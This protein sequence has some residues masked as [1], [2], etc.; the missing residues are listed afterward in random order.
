MRALVTGGGGFIGSRIVRM[1][2]A[3]GDE[4]T[5]LGRR[6]YPE[7]TAAGIHT[8]QADIRDAG[9][10]RNACA[11]VDCV[12]HTAAIA[13]IWG[14]AARFREI[15]V[16][17]TQ[18]VI[19]A[20]AACGVQRLVF[21][22]TPSVVFG[23]EELCG[24]DESQPYPS[25]YLAHYPATKAEAERRVL[26]ANGTR[27]VG[28]K[29]VLSAVA[30]RPHLV[31]GPGDPHLIPRVIDRARRGRLKRV[32]T[33]ENLVD[34]TYIDNA[35]AA[36]LMAADALAPDSPCAGR[37]YFISQGEPVRLW[38]WLNEILAAI[39][40]RPVERSMAYGTARRIGGWLEML[41]RLIPGEAEPPMTRFVAAQLATSHYF[42][43]S[44]A[45]RD[46]GY[47]VGIS[48]ADGF[49]RLI[50]WLKADGRENGSAPRTGFVK[51]SS[52]D[53]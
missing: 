2:H 21:T 28:G 31:W 25:R 34:I 14:P 16:D 17:G 22:S 49:T 7:L 52:V 4:V 39:G 46:F 20:C 44:G 3:R 53:V 12:F 11:G 40:V 43:I 9:A 18:N 45:R 1:L 33:G 36:H 8:V 32:G 5:A 27:I 15:N 23:D 6:D 38:P 48:T 26:A 10:L 41:Y 37:A 30:L 35:A 19:D 47:Q 50:D 13:A 24:V 29:G 42:D 51:A